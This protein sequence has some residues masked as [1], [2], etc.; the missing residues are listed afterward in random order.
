M[1]TDR[2]GGHEVL[3]PI[4]HNRFAFFFGERVFF[5]ILNGPK[6]GKIALAEILSR[7]TNPSIFDNPQFG[8]VGVV[9]A[10]VF[11]ITSV[12]GRFS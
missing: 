3:L 10:M 11:V 9:V 8:R 7:V 4:N 6:L 5:I 12:F 1:I 2:I